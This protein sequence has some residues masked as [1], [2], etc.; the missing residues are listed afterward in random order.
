VGTGVSEDVVDDAHGRRR[1]V[2]ESVTD[3]KLLFR[4]GRG[5]GITEIEKRNCFCEVVGDDRQAGPWLKIPWNGKM[6]VVVGVE[7]ENC[8]AELTRPSRY[9]FEWSLQA[10]QEPHLAPLRLQYTWWSV[11]DGDDEVGGA[12]KLVKGGCGEEVVT[13]TRALME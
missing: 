6:G 11:I 4:W 10:A 7:R 13:H 5:G 8:R 1:R 3:H 12:D 9:H 2:D